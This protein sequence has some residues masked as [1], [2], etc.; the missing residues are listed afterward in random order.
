MESQSYNEKKHDYYQLGQIFLRKYNP[1][2]EMATN[3]EGDK[4][5]TIGIKR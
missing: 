5:V 4:I 1:V 3:D 2:I